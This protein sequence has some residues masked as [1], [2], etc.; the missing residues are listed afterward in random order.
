MAASPVFKSI[1]FLVDSSDS[2]QRAAVKAVELAV[3]CNAKLTVAAVVD[4]E[5]LKQLLASRVF[6]A[7]EMEEYERELEISGRRLLAS[8]SRLAA[9]KG[10]KAEESLLKGACHSA[11]LSEQKR[12]DADLVVLA[13]FKPTARRDLLAIE[14][15]HILDVCPAPIL[16]VR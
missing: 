16:I 7:E 13:A 8:V 4:T 5:T 15:Q 1:L 2:Q 3:C 11:V 10:I 12:L 9:E 14:K 6:V